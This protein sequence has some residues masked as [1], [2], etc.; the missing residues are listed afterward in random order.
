MDPCDNASLPVVSADVGDQTTEPLVLQKAFK[1]HYGKLVRILAR[2]TGD[3]GRAE[4]LAAEAF[5]KLSRRPALFRPAGKN[6]AGWLYRT[7]MNL[8]LDM[9]RANSRRQRREAAARVNALSNLERTGALDAILLA[10]KR[11]H[12]RAV[13]CALKPAQAQLLLLRNGGMSYKE[14]ARFLGVKPASIG[15][16]LARAEAE[17]EKKYRAWYGGEK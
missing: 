13:L 9:I 12:V 14:I 7:A 16:L 4:E 15:T 1:E 6:L 8:G 2:L 10:E 17:F 3:T 5:W 11:K